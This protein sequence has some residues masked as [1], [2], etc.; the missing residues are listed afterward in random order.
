MNSDFETR[1]SIAKSK[2]ESL[3]EEKIKTETELKNAKESLDTT[4]EEIKQM[5][6][7]PET[8]DAEIEKLKKM[9]E[10]NLNYIEENI[11]QL[12]D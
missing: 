10:D 12:E 4:I 9:I 11:P 5:G 1:I 6:V 8:I 2:I 3:K 7:T